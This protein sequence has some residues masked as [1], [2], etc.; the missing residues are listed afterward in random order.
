MGGISKEWISLDTERC[1]DVNEELGEERERDTD[2]QRGSGVEMMG[3]DDDDNEGSE[4]RYQHV[5]EVKNERPRSR[6]LQHRAKI[7][8]LLPQQQSHHENDKKKKE[9]QKSSA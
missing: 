8:L 4:E 5:L 7:H 3:F 9:K 1:A 2:I 6:L